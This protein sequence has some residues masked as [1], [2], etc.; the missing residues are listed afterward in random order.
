MRTTPVVVHTPRLDRLARV[1]Q[2]DAP[3]PVHARLTAAAS[4]ALRERVL[5]GLPRLDELQRH[6]AE[7]RPLVQRLPA[8]LRPIGADDPLGQPTRLAEPLEHGDDA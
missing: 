2:A 1:G 3:A 4:E 7:G 8:T 6:M 5:H